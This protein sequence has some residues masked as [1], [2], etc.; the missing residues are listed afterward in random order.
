MTAWVKTRWRRQAVHTA[1]LTSHV[2]HLT[3]ICDFREGFE[4]IIWTIRVFYKLV[5]FFII[6]RIREKKNWYII[7]IL[8]CGTILSLKPLLNV[9]WLKYCSKNLTVIKFTFQYL[10]QKVDRFLSIDSLAKKDKAK[11][12]TIRGVHKA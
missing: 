7:Y 11:Q 12:K 1:L 2:T 8:S 10:I 6:K 4:P 5:V 3:S 9:C